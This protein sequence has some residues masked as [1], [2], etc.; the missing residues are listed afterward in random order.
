MTKRWK[1]QVTKD[2]V[3]NDGDHDNWRK[4]PDTA[5]HLRFHSKKREN[6]EALY[7]KCHHQKKRS[8]HYQQG[9]ISKTF[10]YISVKQSVRSSQSSTSCTVQSGE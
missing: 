3:S 10:G 8:N 5:I 7:C 9:V 2:G 4:I 1:R 6:A